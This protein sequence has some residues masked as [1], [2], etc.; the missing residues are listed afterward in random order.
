MVE[1]DPMSAPGSADRQLVRRALEGHGASFDSLVR[2]HQK[3]I[4]H[5]VLKHINNRDDAEELVQETF[6]QAHRSLESFQ[7][8]AQFST[9]LTGIA[10][11]LV[12]NHANRSPEYRYHFVDDEYLQTMAGDDN[13]PLS[14]T[15]F[16]HLLERTGVELERLS[17]E[18]RES[19]VMVA[20]EGMPYEEV[21]ERTGTNVNNVKNRLFRARKAL[22]EALLSDDA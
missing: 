9:W 20:M 14:D 16:E 4:L 22:R 10:L 6:L 12:R 21:A 1:T 8:N 3:R 5:F 17:P 13:D 15:E 7:G 2:N 18:L 19:L 11:N